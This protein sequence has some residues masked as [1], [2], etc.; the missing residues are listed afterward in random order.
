MTERILRAVVIAFD[1]TAY[2]ATI[3]SEESLAGQQSGVPVARHLMPWMLRAGDLV[4]V[5]VFDENVPDDR[6]IVA[7]SG[8]RR[9]AP[10]CRVRH[11][12]AQSATSGAGLVLAFNT[13]RYDTDTMHDP[14]TNN[15]RI[16]C[17][18]AGRY[19]LGVVISMAANATG[20]RE[21][22]L[23]LNGATVIAAADVPSVGAGAPT[24]LTASAD[25]ALAAGDY[26]EAYAFQNSG[27]ALNVE[28]VTAFSPEFWAHWIGL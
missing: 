11:D 17:V 27:G 19:H 2:T 3:R 26:V 24:R 12:A 9:E 10:M 4:S 15:S 23:L 22:G 20:Y 16:T 13:E 1:A 18:T 6:V 8:G 5:L 25:Y 28:A 7:S 21:V 14:A